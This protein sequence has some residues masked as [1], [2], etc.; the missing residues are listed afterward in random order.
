[1][2]KKWYW[3]SIPLLVLIVMVWNVMNP[4]SS[5]GRDILIQPEFGEFIVSVTTTGELQAKNST[6]IRGPAKARMAGIW[7]MK[8]SDLIAEG[9]VVNA[10]DYVAELDRSELTSNMEETELNLDKLKSKLVQAKLDSSLTLSQARNE[11]TNLGYTLEQMRLH[12][13]QSKFEAPAIQR[14]AEIDLEKAERSLVQARNNYQTKVQQA[15]EKI[16]IDEAG[17]AKE[18]RKYDMQMEVSEGFKIHA[19]ENGI[20]IYAKEWSGKKKVVG[21]T[22]STWDPVVA[23]LPD[24]TVM[25]SL[26]YVNEVDIQKI[27][28]NQP[29][30]VTMD[31][32]QGKKLHGTVTRIA[33]MGEQQPNSDSKVFEVVVEIEESDSTLLPSMTTAN[34][35]IIEKLDSVLFIPLE[36]IFSP[37][38]VSYVF[39]KSGKG[40]IKQRVK[41][42]LINDNFAIIEQ[43]LDRNDHIFLTAPNDTDELGLIP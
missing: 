34:I 2:N 32:N 21:S 13:E 41:L 31:A 30:I 26:T 27:E 22:V 10:G 4:A 19:P 40:T 8:I 37:D 18:Q 35:I 28:L 36:S 6:D 11:I 15:I 3:V 39:K 7:N 5:S 20:V 23:T 1:M 14:Q 38:S 24:L 9:T 43:G 42:G 17:L 12:M 33:N 29:V 25:E 16:K